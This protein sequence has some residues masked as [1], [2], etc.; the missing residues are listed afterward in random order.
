MRR[1]S[2][3]ISS[4]T[5]SVKLNL[6]VLPELFRL[7]VYLA[8]FMCIEESTIVY[9]L[10]TLYHKQDNHSMRFNSTLLFTLVKHINY[11][12]WWLVCFSSLSLNC[13]FIVKGIILNFSEDWHVGI[14]YFSTKFELDGSTK[15]QSIIGHELLKTYTDRHTHRVWIWYFPHIGH[16]VE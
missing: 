3:D 5:K 10:W 6:I 11:F 4:S 9:S 8:L 16:R 7:L 2:G 13:V 1:T 15:L 12:P 14:L